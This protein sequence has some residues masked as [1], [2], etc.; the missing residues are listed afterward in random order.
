[1]YYIASGLNWSN[2]EVISNKTFAEAPHKG[3]FLPTAPP[4]LL[5]SE[6]YIVRR[7]TELQLVQCRQALFPNNPSRSEAIFLNK[8]VQDA[9]KWLDRGSRADY[10]IYQ[11]SVQN[12]ENSCEAN[13]IW[14]HCCP[15]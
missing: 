11:L 12:E 7:E 14:Y 13:Y 4:H 8:A 10:S 3:F 9:Q 2:G 6:D 1:M 5:S 15:R